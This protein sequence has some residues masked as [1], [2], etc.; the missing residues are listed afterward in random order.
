M[1]GGKRQNQHGFLRKQAKQAERRRPHQD[2]YAPQQ[3]EDKDSDH[4]HR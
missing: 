3:A 1:S 2:K 4:E